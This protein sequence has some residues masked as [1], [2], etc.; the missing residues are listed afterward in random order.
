AKRT[1]GRIFIRLTLPNEEPDGPPGF[2]GYAA[3]DPETGQYEPLG[4]S[5]GHSLRV[6]PDGQTVAYAHEEALWT[7]NLK[8]NSPGRIAGFSGR[9]VWTPDGRHI[10]ATDQRLN[11]EDKKDQPEKPVWTNDTW[12][13]DLSNGSKAPLPIPDTD[14]VNDISPD[15]EWVVTTTDRHPPF[16][17]GYQL[18]VMKTDGTEERRLTTGR[19]LNVHARFSPDG[20]QIVYTH[21]RRG[22]GTNIHV[23]SFDG[24]GHKKITDRLDIGPEACWSPDGKHLAIAM[25]DW[26]VDPEGG[27]RLSAGEDVDYRLIITDADGQNE[28]RVELPKAD[29][30]SLAGWQ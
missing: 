16:G 9:P 10:I 4:I 15:G 12:K 13:I 27:Q 21:Q 19:G 30:I 17:R 7:N 24:A 20:K 25:H 2:R 26:P 14:A 28:R 8:G 22:E 6:S 11:E 23:I 3:V 1:P 18:Y 29:W 5:E